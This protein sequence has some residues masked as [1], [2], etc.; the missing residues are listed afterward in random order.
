MTLY[1]GHALRPS[2]RPLIAALFAALTLLAW[3]APRCAV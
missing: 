1:T 2:L 3:L